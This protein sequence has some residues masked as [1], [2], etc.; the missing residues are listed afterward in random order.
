MTRDPNLQREVFLRNRKL[1]FWW[2]Y[3]RL[4]SSLRAL[5]SFIVVGT[6]KGGTTSLFKYLCQH[7]DILPPFRK[8][9]KYFDC[10]YPRGT[11]WYRSHFPIET[12]LKGT[13]ITGDASPFYMFHPKAVELI[14]RDFPKMKIIVL[15]RNPVERTYSH[16]QHMV[17]T[18]REPLSFR[19]A[20]DA[21]AGRIGGDAEKIAAD[22][23]YPMSN[24][25]NYSYIARSH[26]AE[27]MERI[28]KVFPR[29]QVQVLQS[30]E[31]YEDPAHILDQTHRFIGVNPWQAEKYKV[32]NRG[33]YS[34]V[35]ADAY[36]W[37]IDYFRPYNE[38]LFEI[39]GMR[40]NWND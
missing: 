17:R 21:E 32:Y 25:M 5:P 34:K 14:A 20:L 30:E 28:F 9:I 33:V 7:P 31:F 12:R 27:Q 10:N 40:F 37:L 39:L 11:A 3:H 1:Y 35:D 4:T 13:K 15:L 36:Q 18:N 16:Y 22:P 19:E 26:Y 8:E 2:I 24:F 6:M 23:D 38:R 29:E